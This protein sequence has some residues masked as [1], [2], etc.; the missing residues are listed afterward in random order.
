[1]QDPLHGKR[2]II[3]G[4]ARQGKAL[5]RFAA[6]VGAN[7]VVSD[8]RP[9]AKLA[10]ILDELSDVEIEYVLGEHP[11][12]LLDGA[13]VLAISGGVPLEMPLV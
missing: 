5:A 9:A 13:D 6:A 12:N 11:L 1:M 2:I 8:M 10:G 3:L 7:V 4:L